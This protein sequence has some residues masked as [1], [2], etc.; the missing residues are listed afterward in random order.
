MPVLHNAAVAA[1]APLQ[2]H[3]SLSSVALRPA[4]A[5]AG[6]ADEQKWRVCVHFMDY[7][8][9]APVSFGAIVTENIASG[10]EWGSF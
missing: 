4:P 5:V 10:W 7:W 9:T 6:P 2:K 1:C 8:T 3:H